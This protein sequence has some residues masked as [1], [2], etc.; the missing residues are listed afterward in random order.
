MI[1]QEPMTSLNPVFTV[2]EQI[3]ESIRLHQGRWT[4]G[5][6]AARRCACSSRCASPMPRNVL[7]RY[8]HQLS[9]GMRQRVMIAMALSCKPRLLIADEPTTA[10]DVTIQAQILELI[11]L[12][13]DE[14]RMAVLF[15]THDM[16]VVAEIADRVVVM[17]RRRKGRGRHRDPDLP[18]AAAPLHPGAARRRADA[19]ARCAG[20][21]RRHAS[22]LRRPEPGAYTRRRCRLRS[23]GPPSGARAPLLR[24]RGLKTR[25]PV[26]GG[27]L[28]AACGGACTPSS[29]SASTSMRARRWR[30]SANPA[31]ASR[32]PAA[33][34]CAWSTS[35][36]AASSSTVARSRGCRPMQLRPMRRDIQM[37]FQDPFAS[38]DPRLTVGFSVAEPLYIHGVAIGPRRR[39]SRRLAARARRPVAGPC[40]ALSARV[41]RRPA[42]AHRHCAR[43][44]AAAQDHRRR[45]G[46]VGAGRLDPRADRQPDARSAGRVRPGLPVH[47]ARHGG[48]RADQPPRRGDVSRPDRR[49]RPAP[50]RVRE[51]AASLHAQADGRR[52]GGGPGATAP[53]NRAIIRRDTQPDPGSRRRARSSRRWSRS[54]RP[55]RRHASHFRPRIERMVHDR[56]FGIIWRT[57]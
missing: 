21:T 12:L 32:L 20:P 36:T 22:V 26:R 57:A 35:K 28:R 23:T 5:P 46:G 38:L 51:S 15:I 24:V 9:G 56:S 54:A 30:W 34:C 6:R 27:I 43:A 39:R 17:C 49:D 52:A 40:A 55:F 47:L 16:G 14:M 8:P 19:W 42:P 33:R 2:G 7:S 18:R 13:Q 1:F 37:V 29:R 3:A 53:Q 25:F 41:L 11:R 45:R 10:L 44:G 4:S 50:R 48:G 31:A